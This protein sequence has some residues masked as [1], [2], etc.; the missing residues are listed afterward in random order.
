MGIDELHPHFVITLVL[1]FTLV[2]YYLK[3]SSCKYKGR[4]VR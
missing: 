4:L 3:D 2:I 1:N